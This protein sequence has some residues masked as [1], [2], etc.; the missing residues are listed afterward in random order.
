MATVTFPVKLRTTFPSASFTLTCGPGLIAVPATVESGEGRMPATRAPRT[1][2][3]NVIGYVTANLGLG[4]AAR[5]SISRLLHAGE[6]VSI[7]DIDPGARHVGKDTTFAAL[8]AP[9]RETA[10]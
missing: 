5:N 6:R 8:E 10:Y 7:I 4:V 9:T 2:G 3:F 1:R